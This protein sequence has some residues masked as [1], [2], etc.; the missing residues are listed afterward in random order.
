MFRSRW[1]IALLTTA[2]G[3]GSSI[4]LATTQ[5]DIYRATSVLGIAPRVA[6][7]QRGTDR[8]TVLEEKHNF[9]QDQL[10]YMRGSQVLG[11]VEEK[12]QDFRLPDN[13]TPTKTLSAGPGPG[14]TFLMT[15]DSPNL[16]YARRFAR[17]WASEFLAYK[18]EL[19]SGVARRRMDKTR[20]DLGRQVEQVGEARQR[21]DDYLQEHQ[22]ATSQDTGNSAQQ[23]LV[24][25]QQ[26]R[27]AV[28]LERQRLEMRSV[29]EI[30]DDTGAGLV[31]RDAGA[32]VAG[33]GGA[34]QVGG[35]TAPDLGQAPTDSSD[36]FEKFSG[37]SSYRT[38]KL[39][40]RSLDAEI[41]K[42]S[43]VLKPKHPYM[44][45]LTELRAEVEQE[46]GDQLAL[47][48]EMRKAQI[49]SLKQEESALDRQVDT[50]RAE[51]VRLREISR[52]Y[53]RR[54]EEFQLQSKLEATLASEL[55]ALSQIQSEDEDIKIVEEGSAS[56]RPI[57]PKRRSMIVSGIAIG[58]LSGIGLIFLLHRLDDRIDSAEDL[59]KA[60]DEPILGQLPF[61]SARDVRDGVVSIDK[62]ETN[63]IFVEAL[64][65]V[66]SSIMF[67]ELGGTKQVLMATSS[68]PGDGKSTFTVNFAITLANAGNRVLLIDADLRRGTVA[69]YFGVPSSPGLSEVLSGTEA[70]SNVLCGTSHKTLLVIP[71]G[72]A[73]TNPGE[74]LL[75]KGIKR[76]IEEVR[77]D[78]DYVIFDSPPVIGMDD[79]ASLASNCDGL[80]FVYRV[81]ITS[82]KLAKLAVNTVRQ[83][84]GKILGLILNG[85]SI[86]NPDYYYTAYYY[87]HYTYG[88]GGRPALTGEEAEARPETPR[89]PR[90]L[91]ELREADTLRSGPG[92][93][94]TDPGA[95]LLGEDSGPVDVQATPAA[96]DDARPSKPGTA[97]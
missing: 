46:I 45:R 73:V 48:D 66:R 88:R 55:Q 26:R 2:V 49:E 6:F 91:K 71:A 51:V 89:G 12:M 17:T 94:R 62:L 86:N 25:L 11:K 39:R 78:F 85:V 3:S 64:R 18:E 75:S 40:L 54:T 20:S 41:R 87:S 33:G 63:N 22:I 32:A 83:R 79:A 84:G 24:S 14:S 23:A 21:L 77:P 80:V 7:S 9:V 57:G 70:W 58:F 95:A 38:L 76:L 65:G 10:S 30:A 15:V 47:I 31:P 8:A 36:P 4:Y 52:E 82:L 53:Q 37:A 93:P 69:S 43:E 42:Q 28:M 92:G 1:W 60:L 19:R 29:E 35:L 61:V 56:D 5:P 16:E 72:K 13:S 34:G 96:S 27:Q 90:L 50:Q 81:G 44:E 59:E 97:A 67:G 74:L 68:V